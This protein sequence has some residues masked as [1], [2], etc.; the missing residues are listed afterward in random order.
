MDTTPTTVTYKWVKCP[1]CGRPLVVNL[2]YQGSVT[3]PDCV[4]WVA[5][6]TFKIA[7]KRRIG[8]GVWE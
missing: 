5:Q 2:G 7:L 4:N 8:R 3:C 6:E 1:I